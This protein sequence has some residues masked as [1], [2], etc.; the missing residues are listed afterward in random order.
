MIYLRLNGIR[1]GVQY[2]SGPF[3]LDNLNLHS[4]CL[5][6]LLSFPIVQQVQVVFWVTLYLVPTLSKLSDE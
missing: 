3:L 6:T 1:V 2:L 5:E 4:L